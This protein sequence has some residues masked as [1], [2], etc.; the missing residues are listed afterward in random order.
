MF[1]GIE[2]E[3]CNVIFGVNLRK[4]GCGV[5]Y[6]VLSLRKVEKEYVC[7]FFNLVRLEQFS[8]CG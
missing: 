8:G 6:L 3:V 1:N 7:D 2:K 5:N 4:R